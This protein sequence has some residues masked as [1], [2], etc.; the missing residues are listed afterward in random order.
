MSKKYII[1]GALIL[2]VFLT[3]LAFGS[4]S[5][6]SAT[7]YASPQQD[8]FNVTITTTGELRA[9]NST[10]IRGPEGMREF[11]IFN[12]TIQQIV[13]EGTQVQK[14]DFVAELDRSQAFSTLQDAQLE[15]E[16]AESEYELAQLDT[17]LTLSQARDNIINLEYGLEEAEIALEQS[18]YESP[19]VQRQAQI[20]LER[21][22]RQKAQAEQSY[23]TQVKQA[24]ARLREIEAD[25]KQ[26]RREVQRIEQILEGFTIYAPENG[27]V[28]YRRNRDGSKVS[29]G[30]ELSGW[31]P[32]VAELPDFSTMESV[33]YVNEVDIQK[34]RRGQQVEIGLDAMPEKE[35][36]GE[37]VSVANI[38]EQR[39]NSN[40]K[41][42]EVVIQI[43]DSDST[44]RPA[45]TTGNEIQINSLEDVLYVPLET[46]H[47]HN[48]MNFVFKEQGSDPVMQQVVLGPMNENDVVIQ[49]GLDLNDR[50]YLSLPNDTTGIEKIYLSEEVLEQYPSREDSMEQNLEEPPNRE[51]QMDSDSRERMRE[52]MQQNSNSG[53]SRGTGQRD[54]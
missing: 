8:K 9:Q 47:S 3:W 22:R 38:G 11:R 26:D 21:A 34:V 40:S 41:V 5:T 23:Q 20:D 13:P 35:L 45:M 32:T 15:L 28:I 44:L 4:E 24:Q 25:V 29:E 30:S 51:R 50:L 7:I 33:T 52:R 31:D 6:E 17:S 49:E 27:M 43:H 12:V 10:S 54:N 46:V 37:I 42:F 18:Q 39:P 53:N 19:A 2:L 16:E 1:P 14:G 48:S 36:S